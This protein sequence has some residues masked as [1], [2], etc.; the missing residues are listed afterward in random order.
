MSR[1]SLP[2]LY[3]NQSNAWVNATLFTNWFHQNFVPTVQE[4]LREIG[5]E[6][7]SVLL[8]DNCFAH[9]DEEELISADGK[10]IAKFLPPNVTSLIQPMDQGVLVAI[11][12]RYRRK[13]LEELVC[14]DNN[15]TSLVNFLRG[16]HL[17]KM[18]EMIAASWNEI[19]PKTLRLSWRK[20]FPL[21]DDDDDDDDDDD[22]NQ[23]SPVCAPT[24]EEFQSFF[25]VLGQEL[26]EGEV[27]EWLQADVGDRGY[28][29]L[30]DVE[31]IV[32]VTSELTQDTSDD[33][34]DSATEPLGDSSCVSISHG[35][36]VKMFDSCITW[37]QLQEA[38]S[39]HNLSVLRD[40]REIAAK[41]RL[42]SLNQTKLTD[43][44]SV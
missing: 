38:A 12:R 8:L 20:I 33:E 15:G 44:F 24:V 43:Y 4:K 13:I 14:Q 2:V 17:L 35:E 27:G 25:E 18:S 34:T 37:L 40:L 32:E 7:K 28:E 22:N 29:H 39:P 5:C 9:P 41:N 31:I 26:D 11:K 19:Q 16:I 6:P 42:I 30:S 10:V 3:A 23:E 1:D 21:E 36:A